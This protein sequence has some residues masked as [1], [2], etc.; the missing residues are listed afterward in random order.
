MIKRIVEK[1]KVAL[2]I[3]VINPGKILE[4][5]YFYFG[6]QGGGGIYKVFYPLIEG[7]G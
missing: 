5:S 2:K 7:C 4:K 1:L 3:Q 6:G